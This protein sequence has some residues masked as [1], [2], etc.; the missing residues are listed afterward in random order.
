MEINMLG[1]ISAICL[2]GILLLAGAAEAHFGMVIPSRSMVLNNKDATVSVDVAFAHPFAANGMK[3]ENAPELDVWEGGN[4]S[5]LAMTETE[6]LGTRAFRS[7]FSI[8]RPGVYILGMTPKP[9]YEPA[10]ERFIIH[11]TK[12]VIGAFGYEEGYGNPIGQPV[13][14]I[15][16]TRPFGNYAGNIFS[17]VVLQGGTPLPGAPVEVEFFNKDG[18]YSAPNPYFETQVVHTDANGVFNFAVPWPGWWGFA[19]L[20]TGPDKMEHGGELREVELG[21]VIWLE[22][23]PLPERE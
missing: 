12:T 19:A 23:Y 17:G 13:E 18:R 2:A 20:A 16:L 1:K 8:K 21:G 7:E 10:E 22:F 14:I 6:W 5:R 4:K 11:Y 3:M 15:P 9:Y